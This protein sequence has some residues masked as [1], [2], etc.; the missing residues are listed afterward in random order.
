MQSF[1]SFFTK[2]VERYY[3]NA[4][5]G[6]DG[7]FYTAVSTS[8]FFGGAI[9]QYIIKCLE[10]ERLNLPLN[11]IDIGGNDARLLNDIYEFL[12][13]LSIDIISQSKFILVENNRLDSILDSRSKVEFLRVKT[14]EELELEHNCFFIANELFDALPCELYD[15]KKMAFINEDYSLSF[16]EASLEIIEIAKKFNIKKG[17]IP[18]S[19]FRFCKDIAGLNVPFMI[20]ICDYG[21]MENRDDFSLRIFSNHKVLDFFKADLREH[22]GISDITYNVPFSLLDS[23]FKAIGARQILFKRQDLALLEELNILDLFSKFYKEIPNAT[24]LRESNK[25]KTLLNNLS[26]N[27]HTAIYCNF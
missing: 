7:D 27:F 23:A 19:Y 14:L 18:L 12:D 24:Y 3:S 20:F 26:N 1:S 10:D 16:K 15:D 2:W 21:E 17:E 11:I 6:K 9:A 4:K 8:K 5:I 22:F 25:I 13:A